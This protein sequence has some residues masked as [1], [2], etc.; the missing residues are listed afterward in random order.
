MFWDKNG[1]LS[2]LSGQCLSGK[3]GTIPEATITALPMSVV[4]VPC[5]HASKTKVGPYKGHVTLLFILKSSF[6]IMPKETEYLGPIKGQKEGLYKTVG[7]V[8]CL[9][10]QNKVKHHCLSQELKR[11]NKMAK[12]VVS[13]NNQCNCLKTGGRLLKESRLSVFE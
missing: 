12:C 13:G 10:I 9:S 8:Q 11:Q 2:S 7:A 1:I 6:E 5:N 4:L 3:G